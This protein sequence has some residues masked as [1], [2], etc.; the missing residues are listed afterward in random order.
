MTSNQLRGREPST[1]DNKPMEATTAPETHGQTSLDRLAAVLRNQ[2]TILVVVV[3]GLFFIFGAITPSFHNPRFVIAPLLLSAALYAIVGFS[4]MSVLAVGQMNL[5]VG[6]MAAVGAMTAGASFQFWNFPLWAGTVVGILTG[7]LVGFVTGGIIIRTHVNSFVVTLA[8]DFALLGLVTLVYTAL[9]GTTAFSAVPA[10]LDFWRR[11]TFADVC[12][13]G[14]CGPEAIPV[15]VIPVLMI[16]GLL[17]FMF[18]KLRVGREILA[19]GAN[20]IASELSGI[21]ANRRVLFAHSLSGALAAMAGIMLAAM[22]GSFS[23][24]IGAEFLIPS[25]LGPVLG[26]TL[27]AGG[28]VSIVGTLLGTL[29]TLVIRQGL[30]VAGAEVAVLNLALGAILL[31]ALS[32]QRLQ[33]LRRR[34]KNL[35]PTV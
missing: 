5:A 22:S 29:V 25:F 8:M 13:F 15:L 33:N 20:P 1:R 35:E 23:A 14:Y 30:T 19:T 2:R 26:G 6:R 32:A 11:T 18:A 21:P 31:L 17:F 7:A 10:G 4:Q 9:T 34:R 27:L 16:A 3:L 24:T 28:F 12:M